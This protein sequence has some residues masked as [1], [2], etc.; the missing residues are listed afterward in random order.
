MGFFVLEF[1]RAFHTNEFLI[2][3]QDHKNFI[4]II[5]ATIFSACNSQIAIL[6]SVKHKIVCIFGTR[7]LRETYEKRC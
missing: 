6:Q 5:L 1:L 3:V 2:M 7:R 4:I